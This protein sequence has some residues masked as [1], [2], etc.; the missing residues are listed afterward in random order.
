MN[1]DDTKVRRGFFV[2]L[3]GSDG[4]GKS[5]VFKAIK[6]RYAESGRGPGNME[7]VFTREPGGTLIGEDIRD[8]ILDKENKEMSLRTEAL[9]YAA[10]RAQHVDEKIRPALEEG[11]L[12]ISDRYM[13]SS[14]AYQ[15]AGRGL[16]LDKV[17]RLNYW[18]TGGLMPDLT[19]FLD[20]D[21][22][23]VL[24][25]KAVKVEKD[26]LEEAGDDF[27]KRVYNGYIESKKYME[28]L[29]SIDASKSQ[30]EVIDSC[31]RALEGAIEK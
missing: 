22:I 18:A 29:I 28:K 19:I 30:Q 15:G 11:K 6:D 4:S 31:I 14:L 10:S 21:P 23:M 5:T 26:R 2:A 24:R 20:V 16:G 25:R 8:I 1:I 27:F 12:V 3:E 9:L 17:Y 7:I 13:L